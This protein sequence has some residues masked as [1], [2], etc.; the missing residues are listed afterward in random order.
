MDRVYQRKCTSVV[1]RISSR[2]DAINYEQVFLG[3]IERL[4]EYK[5]QQKNEHQNTFKY[6]ACTT[7]VVWCIIGEIRQSR[8]ILT[9][10]KKDKEK[11]LRCSRAQSLNG[12]ERYNQYV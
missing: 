7:G 1:K 3:I 12:P 4:T 2:N 11:Y 8:V 5:Q 10:K 6:C 9:K